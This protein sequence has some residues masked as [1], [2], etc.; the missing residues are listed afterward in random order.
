MSPA[1]IPPAILARVAEVALASGQPIEQAFTRVVENAL[2]EYADR[3]YG[4]PA[5]VADEATA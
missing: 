2:A 5:V 4:T 1:S 3:H